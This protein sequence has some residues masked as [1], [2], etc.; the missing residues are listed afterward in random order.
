MAWIRIGYCENLGDK[1]PLLIA[2]DADGFR[3]MIV[4]TAKLVIL[5][6]A[7]AAHHYLDGPADDVQVVAAIGE[8]RE[9]WPGWSAG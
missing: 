3:F 1:H 8:Y 2:G 4:L 7:S 6:E 5:T 9:D